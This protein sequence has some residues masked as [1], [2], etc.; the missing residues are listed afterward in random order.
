[1]NDAQLFISAFFLVEVVFGIGY[2]AGRRCGCSCVGTAR[3]TTRRTGGV[4]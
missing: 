2:L 1:M 4:R 3:G